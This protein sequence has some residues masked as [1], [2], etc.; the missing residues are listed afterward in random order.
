MVVTA[1]RKRWDGSFERG[2]L[3]LDGKVSRSVLT[4]EVQRM[5]SLLAQLL[6]FGGAPLQGTAHLGGLRSR[7]SSSRP[8]LPRAAAGGRR[9]PGLGC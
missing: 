3:G 7:P 8:D 5:G 4:P 6:V 9:S 2:V 1:Y